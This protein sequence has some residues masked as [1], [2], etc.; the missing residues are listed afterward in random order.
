[1]KCIACFCLQFEKEQQSQAMED[2][3]IASER[4]RLASSQALEIKQLQQMHKLE[5][6]KNN[7]SLNMTLKSRKQ[8]VTQKTAKA[9]SQ[10]EVRCQMVPT[11]GL[12]V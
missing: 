9:A 10:L 4:E 1:M 5:V 7:S 3:E 2:R 11:C 8:T 6:M 12:I